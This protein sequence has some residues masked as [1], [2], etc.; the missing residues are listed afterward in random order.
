MPY[1][2]LLDYY[3]PFRSW[4]VALATKRVELPDIDSTQNTIS[5]YTKHTG[6]YQW[7]T[8]LQ[9]YPFFYLETHAD[10][11]GSNTVCNT[12]PYVTML[13]FYYDVIKLFEMYHIFDYW[14]RIWLLCNLCGPL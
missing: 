3:L 10:W 5:T 13:R 12:N 2:I 1:I 6:I 8:S 4:W 9:K 14:L 11:P 7:T